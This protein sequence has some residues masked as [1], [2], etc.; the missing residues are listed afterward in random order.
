MSL[1]RQIQN[2]IDEA[3]PIAMKH[4]S[5]LKNKEKSLTSIDNHINSHT[6]P[7]SIQL[8]LELIIPKIVTGF[9][10]LSTTADEAKQ[11]FR[12]SLEAFQATAINQMRIVA[13]A[14][15]DAQQRTLNEYLTKIDQ[16]IILFYYRLLE[17]LDPP[18]AA[19]YKAEIEPFPNM[20]EQEYCLQVTEVRQFIATWR[21]SY[22]NG[23]HSKLAKEVEKEIHQERKL[24]AKEAA[25]DVIMGDNDNELVR[26]IIRRELK[27]IKDT[28]QRLNRTVV[29]RP[30]ST[31]KQKDSKRSSNVS[32]DQ[33]AS[34]PA[35]AKDGK[36]SSS[37]QRGRRGKSPTNSARGRDKTPRAA[38]PERHPRG[39]LKQSNPNR[40]Q[41]RTRSGSSSS[42]R[43][44]N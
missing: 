12:V 1:P 41:G 11:A 22:S 4:Y 21:K 7:R 28:V 34:K 43:S 39:I 8:K 44:R 24:A 29:E 27:P 15:V 17:K 38:T 16:D 3:L 5:E 20:P 25:E 2:I 26:D 30:T 6:L 23:L 10:D 9:P 35:D 33:S 31:N 42:N 40:R 36:R 32:W 18:T 19:L 14:A 13:K 37:K